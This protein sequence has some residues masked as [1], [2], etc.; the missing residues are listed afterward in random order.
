M[1]RKRTVF[2]KRVRPLCRKQHPKDYFGSGIPR[3][4][5]TMLEKHGQ[6]GKFWCGQNLPF[7]SK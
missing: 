6:K 2:N 1:T 3:L 5:R 7:A 4:L